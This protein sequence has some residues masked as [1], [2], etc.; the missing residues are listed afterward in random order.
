M[1]RI[2]LVP[3]AQR[4]MDRSQT[5][6]PESQTQIHSFAL[7]GR[8]QASNCPSVTGSSPALLTPKPVTG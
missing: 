4:G 7:L 1:T 8:G 2:N 6:G 3:G 5:R